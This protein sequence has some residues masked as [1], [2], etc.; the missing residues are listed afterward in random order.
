MKKIL[1][2]LMAFVPFAGFAQGFQVN[3]EG[4]KQI[5]MGHTGTGL[6]LDGSSVFFNPGAVAKLS[7]NYVQ[8]GVSPLWFKSGFVPT[9]SDVQYN[10]A[11]NV[12]PPFNVY[13]VWGP[14]AARWK[15]GLGVYTPYGGLT[16]WGNT[17]AG[18]Y[19][20]E[21]LD[22]KTIFFQPTVSYKL[23]EVISIGAGFVYN[24]GSVNLKRALPLTG[25]NGLQGDAELKGGGNGYGFNAGVFIDTKK[26]LTIGL[27][28]RSKVVTKLNDGDAI[29]TVPTNL[30]ANFPSPN[31]FKAELPLAATT[32]IGF[33]Y[34]PSA[35]WLLALD[36]NY[37]QWDVYKELAFDYGQ[38]TATLAD[39]RSPRNY[40]NAVSLRAGVQYQASNMFTVRAGGG[41][42]S[43]P[44][45]DGYVT[46]EVPDANRQFYTAGLTY[47]ASRH[48]DL[49]LSFEYEH[50]GARTQT[51]IETQLSGTF[52]SNV[53]IPGVALVYHW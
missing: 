1:L 48:F 45:K 9:G 37:V 39:T 53:Y 11:N 51:N 46:P 27:T 32:S 14:K 15:V 44:V 6:L 29:F 33:G 38:N 49:D 31:T 43:T 19:V 3:L 35:K 8:A 7:E 12:A 18:K 4:Q 22:L 47:K 41:Y 5:G 17:W 13:A 21:S 40:K 42:A 26:G 36:A 25:A 50:L 2:L 28:H 16:D 20:L 24:H 10:T 34:T 23:S 30:Q 52:K